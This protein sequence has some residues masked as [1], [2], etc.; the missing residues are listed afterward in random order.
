MAYVTIIFMHSIQKNKGITLFE[1][2]VVIILTVLGTM[3]AMPKY[4]NMIES[5]KSV[6]AIY[7]ISSVR[8]SI[9]R[10]THYWLLRLVVD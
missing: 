9:V 6:E 4:T 10:C 2:T 5:S 3:L 7:G 8:K 1:V